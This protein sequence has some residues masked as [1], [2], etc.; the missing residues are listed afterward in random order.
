MQ[1]SKTLVLV[2]LAFGASASAASIGSP[3]A[4]RDVALSSSDLSSGFAARMVAARATSAS[5]ASAGGAAS[6]ASAASKEFKQEQKDVQALLKQDKPDPAAV[7]AVFERIS[8]SAKKANDAMQAAKSK[9]Q[10]ATPPFL[11]P[12]IAQLTVD[13]NNLL[14]TGVEPLVRHLTANLDLGTVQNLVDARE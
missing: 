9:R 13:L 6:A 5:A 3:A 2:A 12:A 11:V 4:A 14:L 1:L 8:A 7:K 10:V